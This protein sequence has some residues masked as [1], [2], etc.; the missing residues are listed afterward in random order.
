MVT[1]LHNFLDDRQSKGQSLAR[2]SLGT[3]DEIASTVGGLIHML[4]NGEQACYA[5]LPQSLKRHLGQSA[6]LQLQGSTCK[7]ACTHEPWM[8]MDADVCGASQRGI[9]RYMDV[10]HQVNG[11]LC[12]R[13]S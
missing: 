4:L 13:G 8:S 9:Q 1:H 12:P 7:H 10:G 6:V 3:P 5:P 2:P 11:Q